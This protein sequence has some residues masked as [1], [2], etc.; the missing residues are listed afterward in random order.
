MEFHHLKDEASLTRCMGIHALF[1]IRDAVWEHLRAANPVPT[2]QKT[3]IHHQ[4]VY[5][6]DDRKF[7]ETVI[8]DHRIYFVDQQ[9]NQP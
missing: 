4:T 5:K 6:H 2:F 7:Y 3:I 8:S 1:T 9:T